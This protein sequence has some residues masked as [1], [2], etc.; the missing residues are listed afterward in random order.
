MSQ[1]NLSELQAKETLT[2]HDLYNYLIHCS[3]NA[4]PVVVAD[5][6]KQCLGDPTSASLFVSSVLKARDEDIEKVL[7][8]VKGEERDNL[9]MAYMYILKVEHNIDIKDGPI[10]DVIL[11]SPELCVKYS[12]LITEERFPEGEVTIMKGPQKFRDD[13]TSLMQF[14]KEEKAAKKAEEEKNAEEDDSV[15]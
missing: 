10:W 3:T 14:I 12:Q 8:E 1:V 4:I 7:A 15:E 13:Y 2:P 5:L 11:T 9:I 6:K